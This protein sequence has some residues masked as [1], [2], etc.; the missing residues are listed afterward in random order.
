V[1]RK[2]QPARPHRHSWQ[3][4]ALGDDGR[5]VEGCAVDRCAETRIATARLVG[6]WDEVSGPGDSTGN[7]SPARPGPAPDGE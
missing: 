1:T 7:L 6:L 4:I 2:R 3:P 5:I